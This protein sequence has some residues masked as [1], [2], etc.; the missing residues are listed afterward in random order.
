MKL[1]GQKRTGIS[2]IFGVVLISMM[3]A[4]C[5]NGSTGGGTTGNSTAPVN[6]KNCTQVGV[7]LP[8]TATSARWDSKDKPLL[9]NDIQAIPGVH[10]DYY[11]AEGS[12][13]TQ[14]NQADQALTKGDCILV[15]AASDSDSA[16][17]IVAKAKARQI[18]VIAYDRLIQSK[19]LNYYVSFD[20]VKV[21]ELQAQYIVDHYKD[22]VKSGTPNVV[23]INGSQTDNNAILF[24]QGA[25][26]KLQPLFDN[27][28][29][30]K[31]YDQYTPNW[32]NDTARTEMDG[33]LVAQQG[34]VQIAYVANDGMANSVIAS[35]K[36]K[37][38][39]GKVLVTGQ[40]A[41]VAGIQNILVGDQAMTVYKAINKEAQA[42]ADLVKALHDGTSTASLTNGTT[43]TKDG[44]SIPSILETPVAVD[45]T[46]IASTVIADNFVT[47]ADVCKNLPKGA[48]GIC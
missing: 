39:N 16:A 5:G 30:K 37:Q 12:A 6:G 42:T 1:F 36:A 33:A 3:L 27:G 8:E 23:M 22:F 15:V 19:D 32:D 47:V 25:L 29:F 20:N 41:T 11:N 9:T 2:A 45:K 14:Q 4:A 43:K 26:D 31:V 28:T 13:T 46:N 34:N 17:T 40:D 21:G 38:L 44:G 24:R 10:V 48:G 35:L 7:L 18:P